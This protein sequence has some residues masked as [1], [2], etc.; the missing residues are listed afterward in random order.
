MAASRNH[1]GDELIPRN[2]G[3]FLVFLSTRNLYFH[4]FFFKLQ[5]WFHAYETRKIYTC[6]D[7]TRMKTGVMQSLQY[8]NR[9]N[10]N[11]RLPKK[12]AKKEIQR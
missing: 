5:L 4:F 9:K 7:F 3:I 6:I 12:R 8:E 10:P 1:N 2:P 11:N